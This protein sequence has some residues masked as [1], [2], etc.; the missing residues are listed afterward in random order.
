M[1]AHS[2]NIRGPYI[3]DYDEDGKG[4]GLDACVGVDWALSIDEMCQAH[5]HWTGVHVGS[6]SLVD[7]IMSKF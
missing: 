7:F 1:W 5:G 4:C 2:F 6:H 3:Y